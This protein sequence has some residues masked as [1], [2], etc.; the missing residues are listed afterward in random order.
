MSAHHCKYTVTL[1]SRIFNFSYKNEIVDTGGAGIHRDLKDEIE[2]EMS[3]ENLAAHDGGC[4][5][6]NLNLSSFSSFMAFNSQ[7]CQ[8]CRS[9]TLTEVNVVNVFDRQRLT[10]VKTVKFLD[11]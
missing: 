10:K 2:V 3:Q 7:W 6:Q 8:H 4:R 11:R 1:R 5:L 9:V